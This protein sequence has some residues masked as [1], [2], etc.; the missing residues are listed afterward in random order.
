MSKLGIAQLAVQG[1]QPILSDC[2]KTCG[3]PPKLKCLKSGNIL[4]EDI[5]RLRRRIANQAFLGVQPMLLMYLSSCGKSVKLEYQEWNI[6]IYL[7]LVSQATVFSTGTKF[8]ALRLLIGI[9]D[10]FNYW[11]SGSRSLGIRNLLKS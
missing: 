7:I 2:W 5:G 3:K 10:L 11:G 4:C 8:K 1:V 6:E 9:I